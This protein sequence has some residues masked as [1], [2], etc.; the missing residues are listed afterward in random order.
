M[1]HQRDYYELL[2]VPQDA[3]LKAIKEAFRQLALKYHPDRN[4][5]PGASERFKKIAEAYTVVSDPKRRAE[6]DARGYAAVSDFSPENLFGG[7]NFD[8]IFGGFGFD[9]GSRTMFDRL[10][11]HRTRACQ[12]EKR[13]KLLSPS[14]WNVC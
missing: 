7:T 10:F 14:H 1:P 9:F 6:Y 3:D 8:D 12:G 13:R 2:G 5:E 4:K 11:Q